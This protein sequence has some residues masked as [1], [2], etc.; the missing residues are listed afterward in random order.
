LHTLNLGFNP[1]NSPHKLKTCLSELCIQEQK[2]TELLFSK[3]MVARR[4]ILL[5]E[6]TRKWSFDWGLA[7]D[8]CAYSDNHKLEKCFDYLPNLWA[9]SIVTLRSGWRK[10]RPSIGR[11]SGL[12]TARSVTSIRTGAGAGAGAG[13]DYQNHICDALY[14]V[15]AS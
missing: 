12:S 13:P 6:V 9:T 11:N 15:R 3:L 10:S 2:Q 1:S 5:D 14:Y 7:A 8:L 4:I